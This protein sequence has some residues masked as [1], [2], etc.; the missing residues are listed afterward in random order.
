MFD[1]NVASLPD[2]DTLA[3]VFERAVALLQEANVLPAVDLAASVTSEAEQITENVSSATTTSIPNARRNAT[4]PAVL[5]I[6]GSSVVT[7]CWLLATK[8]RPRVS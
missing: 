1:F 2:A 5:F 7:V 3:A 8:N 6:G 4:K